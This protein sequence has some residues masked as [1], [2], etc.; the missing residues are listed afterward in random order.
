M[1]VRV[2]TVTNVYPSEGK[3]RV[4][5]ADR[6]ETSVKLPLLAQEYSMPKVGAAVVTLH[7]EGRSTGFV[8]GEYWSDVKKPAENREGAFRKEFGTDSYIRFLDGQLKIVSPEIVFQSSV[9]TI[10]MEQLITLLNRVNDLENRVSGME[11]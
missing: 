6:N 2:G 9:G 5:Y 11:G 7:M 4:L 8:L 1:I 10:T 3:V